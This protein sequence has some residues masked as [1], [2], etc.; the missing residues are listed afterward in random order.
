VVHVDPLP[1]RV[2]A[3]V[4]SHVLTSACLCSGWHSR[5][6]LAKSAGE[7]RERRRART[8]EV[9]ARRRTT[10][11]QEEAVIAEVYRLGSV[12]AAAAATGTIYTTI[13]LTCA[14]E[15]LRTTRRCPDRSAAA[16]RGAP[17]SPRL[18]QASA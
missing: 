9:L 1:E 10:R 3:L 16:E 14:G 7:G 13:F 4:E 18:R 12:H 8:G 11:D 6:T 5:K 2:L 15:G 17:A